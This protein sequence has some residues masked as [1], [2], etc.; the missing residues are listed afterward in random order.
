MVRVQGQIQRALEK[1]DTYELEFRIRR[2]DGKIAWVFTNGT[3]L[4]EGGKPV[5]MIGATLDVTASHHVDDA[6][7]RLAAIVESSDDAILSKDLN[8]IITTWN[9]GAERLFGYTEHEVVGRAVTILIPPRAPERGTRHP[10]PHPPRRKHRPLRTVRRRKDGTL[11]DVSLTV[12]PLRDASGRVVG[13]SKIA[14]DITDRRRSEEALRQSEERFP[15][16]G[17]PRARR[18]FPLRSRR[19]LRFRERAVVRDVR[20]RPRRGPGRRLDQGRA[21]RRSRA[22]PGRLEGGRGARRALGHR[23]PFP[24]GRR[25]RGVGSMAAPSR[26]APAT[27]SRAT[28]AVAWISPSA[29]RPSCRRASCTTSATG[30]SASPIPRA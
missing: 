9:R 7:A 12:S 21:S 23:V 5:R 19:Q 10:R 16:A 24:A 15:P 13:A 14:R 30:W 20:P 22:D 1:D 29:S 17:E 6:H 25:P 8:G 11:V 27:A 2:P 18:H 3:V 4:R 26:C 28:W